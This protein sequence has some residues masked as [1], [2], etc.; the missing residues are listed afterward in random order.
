MTI[1]ILT[2]ADDDSL[3]PTDILAARDRKF[4]VKIAREEFFA[5]TL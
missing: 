5:L 4:S 3:F 1:K 2:K